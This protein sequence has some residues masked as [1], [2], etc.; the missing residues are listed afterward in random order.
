MSK[1]RSFFNAYICLL[2][3]HRHVIHYRSLRFSFMIA[4]RKAPLWVLSFLVDPRRIDSRRLDARSVIAA[5]TCHRHVIHSRSL[6][7][8][9]RDIQETNL[10]PSR[11][12]VQV[13]KEEQRHERA[14]NFK[15]FGAS[16]IKLA[17]T[18]QRR[19][20]SNPQRL[21]RCAARLYFL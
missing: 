8:P 7:V 4:K 1:W 3:C 5:L 10:K 2:T 20:D 9:T 18:W 21:R 15:K 6:L 13:G 19:K 14:L 11:R 17:P 16:D 12:R